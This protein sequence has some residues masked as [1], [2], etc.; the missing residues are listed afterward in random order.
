R[1]LSG[2]GPL[3]YAV[4]RRNSSRARRLGGARATCRTGASGPRTGGA[5][6]APAAPPAVGGPLARPSCVVL[7]GLPG[8]FVDG[9]GLLPAGFRWA[10][11]EAAGPRANR[12]RPQ[13]RVRACTKIGCR[14]TG[15]GH[16]AA[17]GHLCDDR[18]VRPTVLIVDDH[19]RF[20]ESARAL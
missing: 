19:D 8:V 5:A 9:H 4:A 13:C 18:A 17:G 2:R 20:R 10:T 1:L 6:H 11:P 15:A 14:G 16:N 7:L 12:G 3:R